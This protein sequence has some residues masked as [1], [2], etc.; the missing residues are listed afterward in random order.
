MGMFDEVFCDMPLPDGYNAD[1]RAKLQT[2][3]LNRNLD[4]LRI[5][6]DGLLM[7]EKQY[8]RE[9]TRPYPV[10]FNG[11]LRLC[12]IEGDINGPD[13]LWVWDECEAKFQ[14]SQCAGIKLVKS[15]TGA[16]LYSERT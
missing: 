11:T 2:K 16:Q 5:T 13:E 6:A 15:A 4:I 10:H 12:D 9:D 3:D 14:D 1:G 8:P 7:M